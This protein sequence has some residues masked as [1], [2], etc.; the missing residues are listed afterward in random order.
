[1]YLDVLCVCVPNTGTS[2]PYSVIPYEW[3]W[4][5]AKNSLKLNVRQVGE[6][7]TSSMQDTPREGRW[8]AL[9]IGRKE[10]YSP[11]NSL[12]GNPPQKKTLLINKLVDFSKIFDKVFIGIVEKEYKLTPY[13]LQKL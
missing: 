8:K 1:M 3:S 6:L 10:R 13:Q 2:S 5:N 12:S 4:T 9:L 7:Q 11:V